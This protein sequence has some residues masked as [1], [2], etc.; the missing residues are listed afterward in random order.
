MNKART[1]RGQP[2]C[3]GGILAL[4]IQFIKA[5]WASCLGILCSSKM[6]SFLVESRVGLS[7]FVASHSLPSNLF[8]RLD[9]N[10]RRLRTANSVLV[11]DV[12]RNATDARAGRLVVD[13]HSLVKCLHLNIE[14]ASSFNTIP[15]NWGIVHSQ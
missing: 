5:R 12:K 15:Q 7:D 3:F 4:P 11:D 13:V 6:A 8:Q 2:I 14:S 9:K 1:W 10:I